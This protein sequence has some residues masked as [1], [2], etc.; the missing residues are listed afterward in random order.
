MTALRWG[1]EAPPNATAARERIIDA[2]EAC[3][4]RFGVTKTTI[5]DVATAAGVSR[6]TIYRYFDGRDDIIL[7]ALL[8]EAS[9]FLD[10]LGDRL[11]TQPDFQSAIVAGVIY[12]VKAVR[13]DDVLAL[14]FS[15]ESAGLTG[16][17]VG[18][19]EALFRTTAGFLRPHFE[20][21]LES[22]ELRSDIDLDEAAEWT[23]RVILSQLTVSGPKAR[24]DD[25]LRTFLHTF[26]VPALVADPQPVPAPRRTVRRHGGTTARRRR[27]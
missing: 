4:Q 19:S 15:A 9:R 21:A 11:A 3:F 12:T 7:G 8:R 2:A 1:A 13:A 22:G 5:E 6:A 17:L 20:A 18:A 16:S 27:V 25:E 26:L 10:R 14:L 23:L 24:S